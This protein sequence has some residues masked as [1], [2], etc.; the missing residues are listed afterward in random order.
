M[1]YYSLRVVLMGRNVRHIG[2]YAFTECAKLKKVVAL[3]AAPPGVQPT[4]FNLLPPDAVLHVPADAVEAYKKHPVWGR[5][6]SIQGV[7]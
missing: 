3:S 5:F 4:A 2:S 1:I 7:Q 6:A